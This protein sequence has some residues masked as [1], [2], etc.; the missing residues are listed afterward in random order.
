[1]HMQKFLVTEVEMKRYQVLS[2][3]IEEEL[4]TKE[5]SELPGLSY[6]HTLRLKKKFMKN[7]LEGLLKFSHNLI[8][9]IL[10][11]RKQLYYDFNILH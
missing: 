5:A 3:V 10:K 2:Q 6:R 9:H 11:L 8:K 7:G 1:M 4:T